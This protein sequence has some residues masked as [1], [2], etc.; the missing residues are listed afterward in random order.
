MRWTLDAGKPERGGGGLTLSLN[1][2]VDALR[3]LLGERLGRLVH[4]RDRAAAQKENHISAS[5]LR[6]AITCARIPCS[7]E[8]RLDELERLGARVLGRLLERLD[9]LQAALLAPAEHIHVRAGLSKPD[10]DGFANA[11]RAGW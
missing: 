2:E 11:L 8:V 3:G 1:E 9:H 4:A 7:P 5:C 10:R 6:R